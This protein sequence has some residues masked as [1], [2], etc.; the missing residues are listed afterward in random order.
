MLTGGRAGAHEA[1]PDGSLYKK[2]VEAILEVRYVNRDSR[3]A[4]DALEKLETRTNA[5]AA[6]AL[7][8][9]KREQTS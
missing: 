6:S 1:N 5:L 4:E 3:L 9:A 7:A 8:E 2:N